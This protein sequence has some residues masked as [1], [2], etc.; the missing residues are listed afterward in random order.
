MMRRLVL[1]SVAIV[2]ALAAIVLALAAPTS[3]SFAAPR[4][5]L[6]VGVRLEPPHLDPTAG[7]AA[8][9]GE[10]GYANVFEGLTRIDRNGKVYPALAE[11]WEISADGLS[12]TFFLRKAVTY[13]DGAKFDSSTVKFSLDRARHETSVNPQKSLFEPIATVDAIDEITVKVTLKRATG[14]FLFNM[15]WPAAVIVSPQ[16]A[17][18]NKTNP[19]GTG[20]FKFANWMKGASIDLARHDAYWGAKAKL[21]KISFKI[22]GDPTGAYAALIAGDIDAY[23]I[24]PAPENLNQFRA[25]PRFT[26]VIGNT[27]G[28]TI[29]AINNGKK[30]FDD[31]RVRRALAHAADRK[32][33][34]DGAMYGIGQSIGSHFSPT[35]PGYIDITVLY[36]YDPAKA[37]TLLAAAGVSNLKAKL[38]LPPPEYARRGG[39]IVASQLKAVGIDVEIVPVDWAQWLSDVFK[40]KNYDMTIISH[41]EPFDL[42]I[43]ARDDYYFDYKNPAYKAVMMELAATTDEKKRLELIGKAQQILAD[44]SVNVFLF[45]L[46]KSGVWNKNLKGLWENAPIPVNDL[47]EVEWV[48]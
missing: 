25:D 15:G 26:V 43:Y 24:Y 42:D 47:T 1:S 36:A 7:A 17:E 20:P 21:A 6:N 31:V 41:V 46:P 8:A 27:Q 45:L 23:P 18:T 12:Y 9:I 19:V 34:I 33:I 35:D 28:K 40:A 2:L 5:D 22:I 30:P 29:I 38:V 13:H 37:R 16:S 44:D 11:R 32:A 48:K 3:T 4:S 39:E 14:A 10:I